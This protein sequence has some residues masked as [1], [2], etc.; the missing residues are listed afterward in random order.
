MAQFLLSRPGLFLILLLI[1]FYQKSHCGEINLHILVVFD[2]DNGIP[3]SSL[4]K[5]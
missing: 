4:L 1:L 3:V 5:F 2:R